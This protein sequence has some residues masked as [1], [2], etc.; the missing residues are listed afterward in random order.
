MKVLRVGNKISNQKPK[1]RKRKPFSQHRFG[2]FSKKSG[3]A[4][5]R[6]RVKFFF[7]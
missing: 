6:C 4:K 2:E 5:G 3:M 1:F 7:E